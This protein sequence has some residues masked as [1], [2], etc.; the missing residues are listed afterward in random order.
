MSCIL[1][2]TLSILIVPVHY[3]HTHDK[4]IF[5]AWL[6]SIFPIVKHLFKFWFLEFLSISI[7]HIL[8]FQ[9][10]VPLK[11]CQRLLV[12]TSSFLTRAPHFYYKLFSKYVLE[13][14]DGFKSKF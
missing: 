11:E 3:L 1:D 6:L 2:T 5:Y 7:D 12:Q 13:N 10:F 14:V 4:W 8:K 9:I